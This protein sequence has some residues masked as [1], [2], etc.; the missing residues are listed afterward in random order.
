MPEGVVTFTGDIVDG[1]E[2]VITTI[3]THDIPMGPVLLTPEHEAEDVDPE[4]T[5]VSWE[6][7]TT[8]LDGDPVTIVGYQVI[9]EE[10][11]ESEF[12][13]GFAE[14]VFSA[15]VSASTLSVTIPAEFMREETE[16]EYEVLAI[17]ESGNQTLASAEFETE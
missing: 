16:Y 7:V 12:P 9:V 4:N 17:E 8:D 13:T 3:F 2:S 5:V 1:D 10:D 6:A 15:Y 14:P 11:V